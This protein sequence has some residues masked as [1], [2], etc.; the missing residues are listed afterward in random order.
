MLTGTY[1]CRHSYSLLLQVG[2][3]LIIYGYNNG[4]AERGM[5]SLAGLESLEVCGVGWGWG[6]AAT[7]A[8]AA[9]AAARH[10]RPAP[11]ETTLTILHH[12]AAADTLQNQRPRGTP[13]VIHAVRAGWPWQELPAPEL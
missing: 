8:A 11:A 12:M 9:A 3:Q 5:E 6:G 1:E 4:S 2:K 13:G 7:A 10:L